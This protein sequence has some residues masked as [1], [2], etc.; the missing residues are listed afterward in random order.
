[1][2]SCCMTNLFKLKNLQLRKGIDRTLKKSLTSWCLVDRIYLYI[3]NVIY[4]VV[5]VHI[6]IFWLWN[7]WCLFT[8]NFFRKQAIRYKIFHSFLFPYH[9]PVTLFLLQT[10]ACFPKYKERI[11]WE[12]DG[13]TPDFSPLEKMKPF[14]FKVPL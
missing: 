8:V 11:S 3:I 4:L 10:G 14:C 13:F 1:M 5:K 12:T 7:T 6:H 2:F 9:P